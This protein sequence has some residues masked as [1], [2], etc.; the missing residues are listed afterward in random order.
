LFNGVSGVS[1]DLVPASG[2]RV[3]GRPGATG[4]GAFAMTGP[5]EQDVVRAVA[6][7]DARQ[8]LGD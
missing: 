8:R 6:S 3:V 7:A 1:F 5:A 2:L 4:A